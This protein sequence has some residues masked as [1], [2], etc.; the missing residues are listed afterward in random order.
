MYVTRGFEDLQA[1]GDEALVCALLLV[2]LTSVYRLIQFS[3]GRSPS[4]TGLMTGP[5]SL[6]QQLDFQA[7]RLRRTFRDPRPI[8]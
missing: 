8:A 6:N 2:Y 7:S 5:Q 1:L 3:P 4:N